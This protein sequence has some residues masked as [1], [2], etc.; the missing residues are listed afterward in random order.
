MLQRRHLLRRNTGSE[1]KKTTAPGYTANLDA[2]N[3][4]SKSWGPGIVS[5]LLRPRMLFWSVLCKAGMGIREKGEI[6]LGYFLF[7]TISWTKGLMVRV[8]GVKVGGRHRSSS[9][10]GTRLGPRWRPSLPWCAPP[11][12]SPDLGLWGVRGPSFCPTGRAL[13]PCSAFRPAFWLSFF[14]SDQNLKVARE[15]SAKGSSTL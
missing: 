14:N 9:C 13:L 5:H 10:K 3:E 12:Y 6:I 8:L 7:Q 1:K 11:V 15:Q 2:L 4:V